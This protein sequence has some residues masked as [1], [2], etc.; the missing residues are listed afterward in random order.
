MCVENELGMASRLRLQLVT[1][2]GAIGLILTAV[3]LMVVWAVESAVGAVARR[4]SAGATATQFRVSH[5][6]GAPI[7]TDKHR[8]A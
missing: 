1:F 5:P 7:L 8:P 3:L 6:A 4:N 2:F